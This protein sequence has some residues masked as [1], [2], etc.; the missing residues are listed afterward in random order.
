[1]FLAVHPDQ[2]EAISLHVAL[3]EPI[4]LP[5]LRMAIHLVPTCAHVLPIDV[6]AA[7]S[8]RDWQYPIA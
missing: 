5:A 6:M 3:I 8:L 1:M 4:A 7:I 2:S